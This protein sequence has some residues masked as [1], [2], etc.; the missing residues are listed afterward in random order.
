M[1]GRG[2]EWNSEVVRSRCRPDGFYHFCAACRS[3]WATSMPQSE[4]SC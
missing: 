4:R 2:P 3:A 1:R